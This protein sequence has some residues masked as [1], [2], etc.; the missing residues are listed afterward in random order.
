MILSD[1][2]V[3]TSRDHGRHSAQE[4]AAQAARQGLQT[5]G[6]VGHAAMQFPC[7][8]AMTD[9][10]ESA[11]VAETEQLKAQY[12]GRLSIFRGIELDYYSLP[13]AHPYDYRLG[14]VHYVKHDGTIISVDS[15]PEELSRAVQQHWGGNWMQLCRLYYETVSD[16]MN[17]AQPDIIAHFDLI[18]KFNEDD[19]CFST[20]D[21]R[22][23]HAAL[24]ALDTLLSA[25]PLFEINTGAISRGYRTT[26]YPAPFILHHI[27]QRGGRI[28]L[29][30]D[31]HDTAHLLHGFDN[32]AALAQSCGFRSVWTLTVDGF[33]EI[34]L[35]K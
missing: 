2:H 28:L 17:T 33:R 30:S 11:F 25:D 18:T 3:H 6:L 21:S 16:L 7:S 29:S 32:A 14:S 5:L 19:R 26:P 8:Y 12:D 27:R 34:P 1:L 23:R 31:A 22:Y 9:A 4:M 20:A 24:E 10:N 13:V 35:T 15:D